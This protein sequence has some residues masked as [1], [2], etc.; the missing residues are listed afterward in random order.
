MNLLSAVSVAAAAGFVTLIAGHLIA[1]R[2]GALRGG[3]AG[4]AGAAFAFA[5]EPW[6]NATRADVHAV[7]VLFVAIVIWLLFT[8]R[9]AERAGSSRAGGWLVAAAAAFGIGIG[10]HP[11]VG[12]LAIG[13]ARLA[14][15]RRSRALAPVAPGRPVR[16]RAHRRPHRPVRLPLGPRHQRP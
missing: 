6:E 7:N 9:A 1:E 11:L 13:I 10:A 8:W 5:S 16:G 15:R 3:A 12:L 2:N 4:I 14:L